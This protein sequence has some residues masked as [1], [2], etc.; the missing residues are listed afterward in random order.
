M[1]NYIL[2]LGL[3]Q[4]C[5]LCRVESDSNLCIEC[6]Q[7]FVTTS[8]ARCA[9]CAIDFPSAPDS[10]ICGECLQQRPHFDRTI[11]ATDYTAPVDHL[12]LRLKFGNQLEAARGMA[13][14]IRDQILTTNPND[15]PDLIAPVP[16]AT[17]RLRQRGYN[18]SLE[19]A[20]HLSRQLGVPLVPLLLRRIK[21]TSAQSELDF[22]HRIANVRQAFFVNHLY[23]HE[24]KGMRIGIV[25]DVMTTGATL[26]AIA[27]ELKRHGA[28]NVTNFVFARTPKALGPR[29]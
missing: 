25:D 19:I 11:S 7:D 12:V 21:E 6:A 16:L 27:K 1:L 28:H 29:K 23:A 10:T 4:R 17:L 24:V 5:L 13:D 8:N 26:N 22:K 3:P 20:R 14:A 2:D 15:L 18:Q 9:V